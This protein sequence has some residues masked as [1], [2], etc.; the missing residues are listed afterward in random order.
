MQARLTR[1]YVNRQDMSI[2][3]MEAIWGQ[4]LRFPPG[5]KMRKIFLCCLNIVFVSESECSGLLQSDMACILGCAMLKQ[6]QHFFGH[7]WQFSQAGV[8]MSLYQ[9]ITGPRCS[10]LVMVGVNPKHDYITGLIYIRS[11]TAIILTGHESF[12]C[13]PGTLR[14]S[15]WVSDESISVTS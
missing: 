2:R 5:C 6:T 11:C 10:E 7:A 12:K 9:Y 15:E 4:H 14:S 8:T 1:R 13:P 3:Q